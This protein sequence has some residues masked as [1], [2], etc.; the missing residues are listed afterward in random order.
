[1]SDTPP[2]TRRRAPRIPVRIE[3]AYED[4]AHQVFLHT[5]NLS[6]VGVYLEA[7]DPPAE[8]VAARVLLELPGRPALLRM[9]GV[10]A[11]S[12][13][14]E[15]FALSFDPDQLGPQTRVALREFTREAETPR[16]Q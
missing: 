3:A 4:P 11:R 6:E 1:M 15:G 8:G 16:S 2:D 12:E 10:V 5:R 9:G 7:S 14:G 13:P